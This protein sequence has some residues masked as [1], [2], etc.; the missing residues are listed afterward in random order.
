MSSKNEMSFISILALKKSICVSTVYC[1]LHL[2]VS[3]I[4]FPKAFFVLCKTK[5]ADDVPWWC[6]VMETF[7]LLPTLT[8]YSL[9]LSWKLSSHIVDVDKQLARPGFSL[10]LTHSSY[11][12][13]KGRTFYITQWQSEFRYKRF[14]ENEIWSKCQG[15]A[16]FMSNEFLCWGSWISMHFT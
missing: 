9:I 11:S 7:H 5:K 1:L 2:L 4:S 16:I 3:S 13:L 6:T 8:S 10:P 12:E 14:L 15:K